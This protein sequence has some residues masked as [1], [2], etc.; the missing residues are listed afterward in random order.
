MI[1]KSIYLHCHYVKPVLCAFCIFLFTVSVLN[2]YFRSAWAAGLK[3]YDVK[4]ANVSA[5]NEP[6]SRNVFPE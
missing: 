1:E 3:L 5:H 2:R 4:N 6:K